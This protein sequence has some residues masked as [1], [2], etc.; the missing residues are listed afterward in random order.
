MSP[1]ELDAGDVRLR[2]LLHQPADRT[3]PVPLVLLPGTGDTAR[4]WD[5]V[6]AALGTDRDVLA[7]SLRGH[8]D[9]DWPGA[10]GIDV[11]T[12]DVERALDGW[13]RGPVDLVGH[14]LGGLVAMLVAA[15]RPDQVRR[16][17]LEDVPL[18]RPR[19]PTSPARPEEPLPFDWAVVEQVRPEIDTP[20]AH[21]PATAAAVAARTLLVAGGPTSP[22]PQDGVADLE[23]TIP[24]ARRVTVEAGHLVHEREPERFVATVRAFLDEPD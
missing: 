11:M 24:D 13:G 7:L 21:W 3:R 16:L 6:A 14:S 20:A 4:T 19:V 22:V 17:V 2:G 5:V 10:Y 23:A 15:R 1:I 12:A 8:G 9:S 18:P